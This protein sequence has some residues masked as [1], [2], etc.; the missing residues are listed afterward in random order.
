MPSSRSILLLPLVVALTLATAARADA[1]AEFMQWFS[2]H[3]GLAPHMKLQ[4]FPGMG[5]G[6]AATGAIAQN[7]MLL[8]A[9][10]DI[11]ISR[12][13][14]SADL[15]AALQKATAAAAGDGAAPGAKAAVDAAAERMA[16]FAAITS[17]ENLVAMFL[18][19]QR[20]LG[21]A[22]KWAPYM[23]LLP[24]DVPV[25]FLWDDA[26]LGALQ[27][28]DP[29]VAERSRRRRDDI[30]G[31]FRS[32][33]E[34][35][36]IKRIFGDGGAVCGDGGAP[37][38]AA[39]A[40]A[41]ALVNSRAL[42]IQ[43]RKYLVP[44]ADMFNCEFDQAERD[45][46]DGANFLKYHILGKDA[47]EVR[48]D[49]ATA[50]GGQVFE[51]YGDNPSTVYLEHHG[52][53]AQ[54]NQFDCT[55]LQLPPVGGTTRKGDI[56]RLLRL[57][58]ERAQACVQGNK[59]LPPQLL[60]SARLLAMTP[61]EAE[62]CASV[63]EREGVQRGTVN[64]AACFGGT[65]NDLDARARTV[66]ASAARARLAAFPTTV[67]DDAAVLRA[68]ARFGGAGGGAV[69]GLGLSVAKLHDHEWMAVSYRVGRKR[70]LLKLV[71]RLSG[72]GGGKG[73]KKAA[74]AKAGG[75]NA[76]DKAA[77]Q[78]AE[79]RAD[80]GQAAAA[81]A[82][83]AAASS[84]GGDAD[85]ALERKLAVFNAWIEA[86]GFPVNKLRAETIPGMRV[87][88][89]AT[90]DIA[91]EEVYLSVPLHSIMDL[92]TSR[93]SSMGPVFRM[94]DQKTGGRSDP[95][96]ELLLF[97]VS[98]RFGADAAQSE[99]KPYLDLLPTPAE[100][101]H[102]AFYTPGEVAFLRGSD[103][104]DEL[105]EYRK[106]IARK[107]GG[108]RGFLMDDATGPLAGQMDPAVFSMAH[109]KWAHVILDSR[110]IW[111]GGTRHL[112][113]LLDLINCNQGPNP[114]RVH[115][116]DLDGA[117]KHALTKAPWRFAKG[118]QVFENYGQPNHIYFQFHGFS[119]VPNAHDCL[120]V[121]LELT[122]FVADAKSPEFEAK[123]KALAGRKLRP[124]RD[125]RIG[126]CLR[127]PGDAADAD[128]A[129]HAAA[130]D[131]ALAFVAV[132]G[133]AFP[134]GGSKGAEVEPLE[135][136]LAALRLVE[137]LKAKE[138]SYA[139]EAPAGPH[140]GAISAFIASE[141]ALLKELVENLE[142]RVN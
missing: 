109:Y 120:M 41:V 79:V 35:G 31:T 68:S 32:Y 66:V 94:I 117:R 103:V 58:A 21:G 128:A 114:R 113:P 27:N 97:L 77:Q 9:P 90:G 34:H 129:K 55:Q 30:F 60:Y 142:A 131:K 95:F 11:V 111:W 50:A 121:R 127:S 2:D 67:A 91:P 118:A 8:R 136:D 53:V 44:F 80:G 124:G 135:D 25:T 108:V 46:E 3:G 125:G 47:F 126:V 84:G 64:G 36:T 119:F 4:H 29:G 139:K 6:V 78:A 23:A 39:F 104:H 87:G 7:D 37:D 71:D 106:S 56:R 89:V 63:L 42:T 40:H 19:L 102:P 59:P 45:H 65:A 83:A 14:V 85:E 51:D 99:W 17:D 98:E 38:A 115:K 141:K 57:R 70:Q 81:A 133:A 16:A 105:I 52:F 116:T 101:D 137:V 20:C 49:R 18:V 72:G 107:Y 75:E 123:A 73:N 24:T 93:R 26:Q 112:V 62:R 22:S 110:S 82:A 10:L 12:D 88:T 28:C 54:D 76:G 33:A 61:A 132:A 13:T 43:G 86:R 130:L 1:T 100:M 122:R 69:G 74:K 140:A 96:H 138:A 15:A 5:R 92:R 134:S 48:A